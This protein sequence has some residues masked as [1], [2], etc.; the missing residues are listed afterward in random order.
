[1]AQ[2]P[3]YAAVVN[4]PLTELAANVTADATSIT[5]VNAAT[6]PSA[7]NL[8]T[9]GSDDTAET[10]RY[11][12]ISGNTLTVVRGFQGT[13]KEWK[14][15]AKVARYYTAYDHNTFVSNITD[16]VTQL[17]TKET[18]TGAQAKADAAK[19]AAIAAAQTDATTKANTAETN[20]KNASIPKLTLGIS[21]DLNN[22]RT[23]GF[24]AGSDVVNA[25]SAD[26]YYFE[27]INHVDATS[28]WCTQTAQHF[29]SYYTY[30]RM[31]QEGVWSPWKRIMNE[32]DYNTLFQLVSNGKT[33]I[34][35]AITGKGIPASGS[36]THQ[37]LASKI[38]QI[39]T[40]VQW[41]SGT[42]TINSSGQCIADGLAFTPRK[43][44][45][46]ALTM[47]G[48]SVNYDGRFFGFHTGSSTFPATSTFKVYSPSG[49]SSNMT[50]TFRAG[51]FTAAGFASGGG[52]T[53]WAYAE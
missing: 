3:M 46:N 13:A 45:V 1:M 51:G 34:A 27:V 16:V 20:A 40:G 38:S 29:F 6:L 52:Y 30:R 9:I 26:W 35:N 49:S 8:L 18:P 7:P 12:A 31:L 4:S 17:G 15:G 5:V 32:D 41:A 53:W 48:N 11:T 25:P 42:G 47:S 28:N 21:T 2:Q 33:A 36:E 37:Q 22:I 44:I 23:T 43:V 19:N 24:Y 50:C 39:N 14:A 10:V